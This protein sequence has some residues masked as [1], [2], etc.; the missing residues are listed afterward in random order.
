MVPLNLTTAIFL[1]LTYTAGLIFV[2]G[3]VLRIYQYAT[4]PQPIKIPLTPAPLTSGGA[5]IRIL[6]EVFFFR[7]LFRSNKWTWIFGYAFHVAFFILI[8]MHFLRHFVYVSPL[9]WWYGIFVGIGIVCGIVM[10]LALF[11]LF[12]RRI[13]VERV[14]FISLFA[15]YIILILLMLIALA[16]LFLNYV[17]S[18]TALTVIDKHL[19]P[20][21]NGILTLQFANIP[22]SPLF[23]IHYSLVLLLIAYIPFSKIMHF[24]GIF[25]SPT[26]IMS[27]NPMEKRYYKPRAKDLSI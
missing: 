16:G 12:L 5:F 10:V 19:G 2:I 3:V 23:L 18:P 24:V 14:K 27:D 20:Y 11:L 6:G 26:R 21:V 25:F 1:L 7:S 8:F 9:P 4:T 17:I 13:I 15:D 22:S